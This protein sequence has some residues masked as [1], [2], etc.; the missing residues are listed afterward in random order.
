[1]LPGF[2][3]FTD[4]IQKRRH[5]FHCLTRFAACLA[6]ERIQLKHVQIVGNS[7]IYFTVLIYFYPHIVALRCVAARACARQAAWD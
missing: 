5:R 3:L 2:F 7:K 4:L 6:N 1:M